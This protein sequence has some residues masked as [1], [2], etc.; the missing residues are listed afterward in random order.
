MF[1]KIIYNLVILYEKYLREVQD[2]LKL[3]QEIISPENPTVT[4]MDANSLDD[5]KDIYLEIVT[6]Q[7]K[8]KEKSLSIIFRLILSLE[9]LFKCSDVSLIQN[10]ISL[11]FM[12][13]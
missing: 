6:R 5:L 2:Y 4:E 13:W 1:L 9:Y 10:T 12:F 11:I 8:T 3:V 7:K